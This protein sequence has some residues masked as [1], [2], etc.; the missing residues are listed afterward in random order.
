MSAWIVSKAHIDV[1]VA[2]GLQFSKYGNL[3]FYCK[4][5]PVMELTIETA[6]EFG[7]MLWRENHRSVNYRYSE[8]ERTPP[9]R[10]DRRTLEIP[11]DPV[12]VLKLIGCYGY[13]TCEHKGYASSMAKRYCD[14]LR[15]TLIYNLE[16]YDEGPWGIDHASEAGKS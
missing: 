10:F 5:R 4:G 16:G 8:R 1:L 2:A 9:Y 6:D 15:D 12:K 3:T 13:Q 7:K 14:A 11:L